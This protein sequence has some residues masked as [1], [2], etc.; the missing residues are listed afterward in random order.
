MSTKT[1]TGVYKI[2]LTSEYKFLYREG[3]QE[4]EQMYASE[5]EILQ[6][7]PENLEQ[8]TKKEEGDLIAYL[9]TKDK[10]LDDVLRNITTTKIN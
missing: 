3:L 2:E 4:K 10:K 1:K 8:A 6:N 5:D 9:L 7:I